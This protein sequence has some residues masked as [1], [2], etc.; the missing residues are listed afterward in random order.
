MFC[1]LEFFIDLLHKLRPAK[2]F[3]HNLWP[4]EVFLSS[5]CGLPVNSNLSPLLY[6]DSFKIEAET[7]LV[8]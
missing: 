3:P 8:P 6:R 7:F 4:R 5:L 1:L 2:D